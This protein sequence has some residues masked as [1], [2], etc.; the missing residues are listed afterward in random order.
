MRQTKSAAYSVH[1]APVL[2]NTGQTLC[3]P[4]EQIT[5]QQTTSACD[6]QAD[7]TWLSIACKSNSKLS[8]QIENVQG[9]SARAVHKTQKQST[10]DAANFRPVPGPNIVGHILSQDGTRSTTTGS[11]TSSNKVIQA[12]HEV[13]DRVFLVCPTASGMP[14]ASTRRHCPARFSGLAVRGTKRR[15]RR[16]P[17]PD[18]SV[19]DDGIGKRGCQSV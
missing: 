13:H 9:F 3:A 19:A 14:P 12:G 1:E 4:V 7:L 5:Q 6:M 17:T 10:A 11:R 8:M 2:S 15:L 16:P 18:I